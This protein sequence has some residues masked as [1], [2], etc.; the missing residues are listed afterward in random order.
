MENGTLSCL[1]NL[2]LFV[3][4]LVT[5]DVLSAANYTT[6]T[7]GHITKIIIVILRLNNRNISKATILTTT[8]NHRQ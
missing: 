1:A 7:Y 6:T 5:T 2:W 3:I 8:R 4:N